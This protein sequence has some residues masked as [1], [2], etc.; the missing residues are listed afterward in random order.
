[1][2]SSVHVNWSHYNFS[3]TALSSSSPM[4][5]I[6]APPTTGAAHGD[7]FSESFVFIHV[8]THHMYAWPLNFIACN[9]LCVCVRAC[10]R[11]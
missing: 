9:Y 8:Y 11:T 7:I 3:C 6:P 2:R 5:M 10:V 1:M 4:S